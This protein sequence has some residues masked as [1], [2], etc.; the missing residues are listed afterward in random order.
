MFVLLRGYIGLDVQAQLYRL[1]LQLPLYFCLLI[2]TC[3][4][5]RTL[6]SSFIHFLS[7]ILSSK[8]MAY[9][10]LRQTLMCIIT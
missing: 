9:L 6:G 3:E 10:I 1:Q 4:M 8:Q 5:L 7:Y 2:L